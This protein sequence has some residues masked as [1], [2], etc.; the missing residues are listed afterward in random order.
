MAEDQ[1][2]ANVD[3]DRLHYVDLTLGAWRPREA[4][5]QLAA[6]LGVPLG[7]GLGA[8]RPAMSLGRDGIDIAAL[9]DRVVLLAHD[10]AA[11]IAAALPATATIVLLPPRYDRGIGI[12]N[13]WFFL[14]LRRQGITLLAVGGEPAA[15]VSR[16]VFER[17]R[18]IE[19]PPAGAA[20]DDL[21]EDQRHILRF[22]PGL[23][24]K[25]VAE[26]YG[27]D[28]QA[29]GLRPVGDGAFLIPPGYRDTDPAK[30]ALSLDAMEALESRD[31]GF[32]ALAQ[33]HCTSHFAGC[34]ALTGLARRALVAGE[35]DLARDL[36]IRARSVARDPAAA[37]S[38][39]LVRQEI[40]L[41]Q[42]RFAEAIAQPE[43]S[44]RAPETV[45]ERLDRLK[46][47]AAIERGDPDTAMPGLGELVAGLDAK[48]SVGDDDLH[49]LLLYV[50]SRVAAGDGEAVRSLAL[51]LDAALAG[52]TAD[53]RLVH[54]SAVNLARLARLGGDRGAWREQ[55]E[56]AFATSAGA[57]SLGE[58][59]EMN[60]LLALAEL[61]GAG[62]EAR[63]AWLRAAL[64][65]LAFEPVEALPLGAVE[66]VLGTP[67]IPRA[68]LDLRV[69][70]ALAEALGRAWPELAGTGEKDQ[71]AVAVVSSAR[72][73]AR[74]AR[75]I[76]GPGVAVL[77]SP[78]EAAGPLPSGPRQTL[79]RYAGAGLRAL[80]PA[81]AAPASGTIVVDDNLG[82][83]L[84]RTREE[85]LSVALRAG[86]AE[87]RFGEEKIV[88]DGAT[89]PRIAAD[90]RVGL[91]PIVA[92]LSGS[93]HEM[94][95]RFRRHLAETTVT[96]RD[97]D[98]VAPLKSR[99]R[100]PLGSLAVL[101]GT[102][103]ADTER[104]LRDLEARGIVRVEAE[105]R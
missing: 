88:L 17:R 66:A 76:G 43:P 96:G 71:P 56:R 16:L 80:C 63:Q 30:A 58:I 100:M 64:A 20:L 36:A 83:D 99:G 59:I 19:A 92:D 12:G 67:S 5:T 24:P 47:R 73:V 42:R 8:D 65:W 6:A 93:D 29:L 48:P 52:R 81:D 75:L 79:L 9:G 87:V 33:S 90:L 86:V 62:P 84:P 70:E 49:L 82:F 3:A 1:P 31:D 98:L 18:N 27:L 78:V 28:T 22:F 26:R 38:A 85:A 14:F 89:R 61:D 4:A 46:L 40:R 69:S 11:R 51:K 77:W 97:A 44:R 57:R 105:G 55:L 102:T 53:P 95:V 15:T 91:S 25:P 2:S 101:F 41:C 21:A 94:T 35:I 74:P 60:V 45:R 54:L 10:D 72:A 68:Q 39:D 104:Q 103:L 23:L 13:D 7:P 37:A 50:A 32:K 34:E